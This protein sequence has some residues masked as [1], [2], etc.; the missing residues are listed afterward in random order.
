[1][2]YNCEFHLNRYAFIEESEQEPQKEI[3]ELCKEK[4]R[5]VT[6]LSNFPTRELLEMLSI[7]IFLENLA[8][9]I[10]SDWLPED[11]SK[12]AA[13]IAV[14]AGSEAILNCQ[15]FQSEEPLFREVKDLEDKLDYHAL[16]EGYITYP[17]LEV[18]SSE[19]SKEQLGLSGP[20]LWH[21]I[22]T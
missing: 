19:E 9:T 4:L 16:I 12:S 20:T 21:F 5:R 7:A 17:I 8:S 3:I 13:I 2:L 22:S 1:M 18:V 14:A 11:R 10:F 6:F 15:H